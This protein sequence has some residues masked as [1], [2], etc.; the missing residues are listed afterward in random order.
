MP[1]W[2][3]HHA[4][5]LLQDRP[6]IF[7]YDKLLLQAMQLHTDIQVCIPSYPLDMQDAI[8]FGKQFVTN[9]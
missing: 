4:Y 7:L 2:C 3:M 6:C 5:V 1:L 8:S 9:L